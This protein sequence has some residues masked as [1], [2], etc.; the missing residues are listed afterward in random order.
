MTKEGED[1]M[2][3]IR[4]IFKHTLKSMLMCLDGL[5]FPFVLPYIIKKKGIKSIHLSIDDVRYDL[6]TQGRGNKLLLDL[7][8]FLRKLNVPITLF[9]Y[10]KEELK[11]P[12][13]IKKSALIKI[14]AHLPCLLFDENL[15]PM[16]NAK[17]VRFHCYMANR[18]EIESARVKGISHLLCCHDSKRTSYDLSKE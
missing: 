4:E 7:M 14:G 2:V 11:N 13:P 17:E 8:S 10:N 1:T 6:S 18:A 16:L 15:K 5:L 3:R 9:L 12:C